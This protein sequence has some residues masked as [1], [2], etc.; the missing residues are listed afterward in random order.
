MKAAI[1]FLP[2]MDP[3]LAVRLAKAQACAESGMNPAAVS[4]VG[5]KG[6]FQFMDPT[7]GDARN[8]KQTRIGAATAFDAGAAIEAWGWYM[9]ELR[10]F[11]L[12]LP[13]MER[14]WH[15]V[16][17]YNAGPGWIRK[18]WRQCGGF[19]SIAVTL[20]CLPNFTGDKHTKETTGYVRR[21]QQWSAP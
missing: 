1:A 14:H 15:A 4:P 6:L 10:R 21:N 12:G 8:A 16:A 13:D 9:A 5:A 20:A 7:W 3:L 19:A 18:A 17:S 11:W 2:E